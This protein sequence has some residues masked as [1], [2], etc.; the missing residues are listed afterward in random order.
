LNE[1]YGKL[2]HAE[3]VVYKKLSHATRTSFVRRS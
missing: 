3:E 1:W 2:T